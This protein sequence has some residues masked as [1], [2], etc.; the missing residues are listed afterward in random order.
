LRTVLKTAAF[1]KVVV[2]VLLRKSRLRKSEQSY[3]EF[4]P[5]GGQERPANQERR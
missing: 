3:M 2:F 5:D 1:Q 4:P